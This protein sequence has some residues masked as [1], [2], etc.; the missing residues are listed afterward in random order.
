M[1]LLSARFT[2]YEIND[3]QFFRVHPPLKP[4]IL[5]YSSGLAIEQGLPDIRH[6]ELNN[7]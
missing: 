2:R 3:R 5:F 1:V 4:H 7:V 6:I